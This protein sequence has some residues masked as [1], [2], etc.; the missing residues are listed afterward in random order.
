MK[1]Y[2]TQPDDMILPYFGVYIHTLVHACI[3]VCRS[4]YTYAYGK[5]MMKREK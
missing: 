2:E 5:I 4:I 3:C 1:I